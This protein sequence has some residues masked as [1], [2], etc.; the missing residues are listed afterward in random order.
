MENFKASY[1][2]IGSREIS[3]VEKTIITHVANILSNM[4]LLLYSGNAP[5]SDQTFQKASNGKC[6]VFLPWDRF[7]LSSF[8]YTKNAVDFQIVGQSPQGIASIN[9]YHPNPKSLGQGGKC[10]MA[11]NWHQINGIAKFP[12]V[13]FVVCCATPDGKGSCIGGTSQA[14]RIALDLN[15]PVINIR[16]KNWKEK[17]KQTC[18]EVLKNNG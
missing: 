18:Q 11:R 16:E 5:G 12:M 1:A 3:F 17:L 14:V 2:G 8:D 9:K 13:S 4:N 7:E 6:V 15:I 10:L